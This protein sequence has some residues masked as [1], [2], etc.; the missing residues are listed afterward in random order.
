MA[1]SLANDPLVSYYL[2]NTDQDKFALFF[3]RSNSKGIQLSFI[4]ILAAKLYKGFNL[5]QHIDEFKD[6]YQKLPLNRKV[7]VRALS[8]MVSEGKDTGRAFI[9]SRLTS[10][11]FNEHWGSVTELYG[12]CYEYLLA[13]HMIVG[14]AWIPYENMLIPMMMFLRHIPHRNFVNVS[15]LQRRILHLWFWLAIMSRR[16]SSA[17]QTYVLEDAQ[18][19][20]AVAR[21]D[22]STVPL[23]LKKLNP[24]INSIDDLRTVHKQYDAVYKGIL[25]LINYHSGGLIGWESGAI[26][27]ATDDL[28]NHHI[29]PKDYLQK[30]FK[31]SNA[32]SQIEI[33]CV[34]NRCLIPK[35]TNIKASNKSPSVYLKELHK[36]NPKIADALGQHLVP[37]DIIE[38]TYDDIYDMFLEDRGKAI[39]SAL[40]AHVFD[41][42]SEF[43]GATNA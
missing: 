21:E 28:D 24:S 33:D 40:K 3:E 22:F 19:L 15:Q 31:D 41:V 16:Y 5:R 42:R 13:N 39:L 26:V 2:L 17:A 32:D 18:V 9:L 27:S 7:L 37:I 29:F 4:D 35:L 12:R 38:G 34:I 25:N 23:L 11:H 6:N 10:A 20:E 30:T 1:T 8:Y 36:R 43:L 14:Y